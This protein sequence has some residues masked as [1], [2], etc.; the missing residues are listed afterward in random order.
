MADRERLH[1]AMANL[2]HNAVKYT[3]RGGEVRVSVWH[4]RDEAGLTVSDNGPGISA[5]ALPHVFDRFFRVE[6][7]RPRSEGGS[8][9]RLAI[10]REIV[11]AH[12]GRGRAESELGKGRSF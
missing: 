3:G 1:H 6:R 9:L 4:G 2:L 11:Q 10:C 5:D 12:G 7:A 8:G